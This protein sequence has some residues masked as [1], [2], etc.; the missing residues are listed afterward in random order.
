LGEGA[1]GEGRCPIDWP[2]YEEWSQTRDTFLAPE[3]AS[4]FERAGN[5]QLVLQIASDSEIGCESAP[6]G[7]W[8]GEG[9]VYVCI[10]K[11][12]LAERRFDRCWTMWKCS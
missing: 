11:T 6:S 1:Q 12:D 2:D 8:G 7:P 3:R 9:L 5:W 10:R 4:Y